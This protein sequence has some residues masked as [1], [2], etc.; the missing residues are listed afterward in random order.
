MNSGTKTVLLVILLALAI[1]SATHFSGVKLSLSSTRSLHVDGAYVKDDL[2][3]IIYLRGVNINTFIDTS[4]GDFVGPGNSEYSALTTWNTFYVSAHLQDWA[5]HGFNFIRIIIPC[6]WWMYNSAKTMSGAMTAIGMR[7]AITTLVS[8]AQ[9]YGVY[10][11]V[12][13]WTL[14]GYPSSGQ[15]RSLPWGSLLF[16]SEGDFVK[17]WAGSSTSVTNVLQGFNNVVFEPF[18]EPQGSESAWFGGVQDI[19]D[20]VRSVSQNLIL[21]QFGYD[22][23]FAFASAYPL[24]G[25]NIVWSNHIYPEST[26]GASDVAGI[27]ANLMSHSNPSWGYYDS[28]VGVKPVIIGEVGA[29]GTYWTSILQVMKDWHFGFAAWIY[30]RP[31]MGYAMQ[32]PGTYPYP[33]NSAGLAFV[34]AIP[35][36]SLPAVLCFMAG[37][38]FAVFMKK[39]K[40]RGDKRGAA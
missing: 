34:A 24:T 30:D 29:G 32:N 25:T 27:K 15:W 23:S 19:I 11:D 8:M 17:F 7:D 35:E 5:G 16:P 20:A 2:G 28:V 9:G 33:L 22:N 6:D 31:D 12:C 4:T 36:L 26:N 38:T 1:F 10:V 37:T 14:I 13:P 21:V 39:R 18:N 3:N 40:E